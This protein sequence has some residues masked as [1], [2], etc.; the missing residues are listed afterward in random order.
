MTSYNIIKEGG[1]SIKNYKIFFSSL[2]YSIKISQR[3]EIIVKH[4]LSFY[5]ALFNKKKIKIK[6]LY[7]Y[8]RNY[9]YI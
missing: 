7:L 4:K 3:I 5:I 2:L 8:Y 1:E 6:T 9:F